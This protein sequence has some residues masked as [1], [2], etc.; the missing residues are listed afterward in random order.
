MRV[1]LQVVTARDNGPSH[2]FDLFRIDDFFQDIES[3]GQLHTVSIGNVHHV[4]DSRAPQAEEIAVDQ[5]LHMVL[6]LPR[7]Q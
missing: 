1:Q 2:R 5:A 6:A 3:E 4:H 7:R